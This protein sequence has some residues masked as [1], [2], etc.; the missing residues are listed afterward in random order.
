LPNHPHLPTIRP[1]VIVLLIIMARLETE[2]TQISSSQPAPLV[3][4]E[5]GLNVEQQVKATKLL[6]LQHK[7]KE[8]DVQTKIWQGSAITCVILN[9]A[10]MAITGGVTIYAGIVAI[11]LA[12]AVFVFQFQIRDIDCTCLV[13]L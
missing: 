5:R 6:Q 10:S 12:I 13:G 9:L 7:L 4:L 11:L 1:S 8:Q 3:D 2:M